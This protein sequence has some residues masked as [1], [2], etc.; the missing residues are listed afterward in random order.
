M[1]VHLCR[2]GIRSHVRHC[3]YWLCLF[4]FIALSAQAQRASLHA[5]AS[6]TSQLDEARSLVH[7]GKTHEA[8]AAVRRYLRDGKDGEEPRSLLGLILYQEGKPADSLAAF[9]RAAQFKTPNASELIVVGLDYVLLKDLSQADKWMTVAVETQPENAAGWRYLGGI[10]YSENRFAEAIEVYEKC[11][12]MHPRDVMIEDAIAR[13]LEGLARDEDAISAYRT[14][15]AWQA[16]EREKHPEPMLHLG[17]LLLKK[18]NTL[19]SLSLLARA[20]AIAPSNADVHE[21]LGTLWAKTGDLK[22]SQTELLIAL[23]LSPGNSHLHWLLA[24]VYRREGLSDEANRELR[25]YSAL[26]GAHSSDRLQ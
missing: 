3:L 25:E 6:D 10:K 14:A 20:E 1:A 16:D 2:T 11:L 5:T 23:K 12:K 21:E 15:L 13:S 26:L 22:K 8:E 24:S 19:E 7:E 9:T 17:T 18:G 4:W